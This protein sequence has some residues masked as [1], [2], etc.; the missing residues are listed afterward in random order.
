MALI[1]VCALLGVGAALCFFDMLYVVGHIA[2]DRAAYVAIIVAVATL[3]DALFMLVLIVEVVALWRG[4]VADTTDAVNRCQ[5]HA[6]A[7]C[8]LCIID[9]ITDSLADNAV[10]EY[11]LFVTVATCIVIGAYYFLVKSMSHTTFWD[12]IRETP[13]LSPYI[14]VGDV[15]MEFTLDASTGRLRPTKPGAT[16][17]VTV[18]TI[19]EYLEQAPANIIQQIIH[20]LRDV[21]RSSCIQLGDAVFGSV[22]I[23][24]EV[25]RA[26]GFET[27]D[28]LRFSYQFLDG[29]LTLIMPEDGVERIFLAQ[30]LVDQY[31]AKSMALSFIAEMVVMLALRLY[32]W[33]SA[34]ESR[35]L[36]LGENL[37]D[38]V[39]EMPKGFSEFIGSVRRELGAIQAFCRQTG[40]M[41]EDLTQVARNGGYERAANQ[42]ATMSRQIA[43]LALDA[44]DVRDL[45][46]EIRAGFQERIEV[47]QNNVM[48]MLTIV[49]T[50]FTPLVLVT[51]WYGMNF[52]NMPELKLHDAYFIVAAALIFI[53]AAE[54]AYFKHR[55]W[56]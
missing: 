23:A 43:R 30:S 11:S 6:I 37:N 13:Q 15:Y 16:T 25:Q 51:G 9:W 44:A 4:E 45:A 42:C 39:Y 10:N 40:D 41:L 32:N 50:V 54:F 56:F 22:F 26:A 2:N 24:A 21:H 31:L 28:D 53:I 48:S 20:T 52:V 8:G 18:L 35:L 12:G 29:M 36:K 46:G 7:S 47:R 5:S 14:T 55:R 27:D 34:Y 17:C 3:L 19:D 38:E 1:V 49:E 33:L